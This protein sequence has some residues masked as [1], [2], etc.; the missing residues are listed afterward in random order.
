MPSLIFSRASSTVVDSW[1]E[2]MPV[3]A[4][5]VS[6]APRAPAPCPSRVLPRESPKEAWLSTRSSPSTILVQYPSPMPRTSFR[7][8]IRLNS[9]KERPISGLHVRKRRRLRRREEVAAERITLSAVEKR[10]DCRQAARRRHYAAFGDE[11]G[12]SA[13]EGVGDY[14]IERIHAVKVRVGVD[15]AGA[16]VPAACVDNFRT[17]RPLKLRP[18]AHACDIAVLDRDCDDPP[19]CCS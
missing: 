13:F 5:S 18:F 12:G 2:V 19:R 10:F 16:E 8:S 9:R 7:L 17:C 11:A 6:L 1:H 14:L 15:K 4:Y 3:I